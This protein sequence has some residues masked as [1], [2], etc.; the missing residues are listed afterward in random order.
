MQ[1][2]KKI[3]FAS[4]TKSNEKLKDFSSSTVW[5]NIFLSPVV[6]RWEVAACPNI[7]E[8]EK[9]P[10]F[11]F[12]PGPLNW[13][14]SIWV[15]KMRYWCHLTWWVVISEIICKH[16]GTKEKISIFVC[17]PRPLNWKRP[18]RRTLWVRVWVHK[19]EYINVYMNI[20]IWVWKSRYPYI[21]LSSPIWEPCVGS[22]DFVLSGHG[23]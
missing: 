1:E 15:T 14:S 9:I 3:L 21:S 17:L 10:V 22:Y 23:K 5:K 2:Q 7:L 16:P 18:L 11:V 19:C 8:H 12:S 6:S 20:W 13:K 4:L